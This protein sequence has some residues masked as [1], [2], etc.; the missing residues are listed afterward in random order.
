ME[1]ACP[2]C[3]YIS[4]RP[5]RFC[6]QC[7]KQLYAETEASSAATRNYEPN[8]VPTPRQQDRHY[9]S[10]G[11]GVNLGMN[12][13][14]SRF[15]QPP[16]AP[17]PD[18][19]EKKKSRTVMWILIA[20]LCFMMVSISVVAAIVFLRPH[21]QVTIVDSD[22][23]R[24]REQ[25]GKIHPPPPPPFPPADAAKTELPDVFARYKYPNA[26]VDNLVS[27]VGNDIVTL[28]TDDNVGT[29]RDFYS[30][31]TG[32]SPLVRSRKEEKEEVVFQASNS[33]P[34]LIIISP[35]DDLPGKTQIVLIH[36]VI[37]IPR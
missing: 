26:Q 25:L 21:R 5:S 27:A 23:D 2:G 24:I 22:I 17:Y 9:Y 34:I 19:P 14:T 12:E 1:D 8:R 20:V 7:G 30:K 28:S 31:V 29:V 13:E 6:R 16:I 32:N 36:S 4:D 33:P 18:F 11:P 35:D 37:Q 10:P 3:G 15:Y